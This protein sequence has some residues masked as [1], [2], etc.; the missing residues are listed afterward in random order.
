MRGGSEWEELLCCCAP[1]GCR[2]GACYC[3]LKLALNWLFH[4]LFSHLLLL[5]MRVV[6]FNTPSLPP[7]LCPLIKC[8]KSP[9]GKKERFVSWWAMQNLAVVT[10]SKFSMLE[11]PCLKTW[12]KHTEGIQVIMSQI[13]SWVFNV[14]VRV[15]SQVF[16]LLSSHVTSHKNRDSSRL[17][18]QWLKLWD[19]CSADSHG[20]WAAMKL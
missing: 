5:S 19:L 10:T 3:P 8:I 15:K 1:G 11:Q 4:Q 9:K 6:C 14:H 7:P 18:S 12:N 17:K 13:K 20:I 2:E 16:Y